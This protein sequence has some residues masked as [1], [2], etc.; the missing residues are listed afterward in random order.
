METI[1]VNYKLN[2][3]GIKIVFSNAFND[4]GIHYWGVILD[5]KPSADELSLSDIYDNNRKAS[6]KNAEAPPINSF[7]DADTCTDMLLN[8]KPLY[9]LEIEEDEDSTILGVHEL[10]KEN[11]E[12]GFASFISRSL[13]Q[14]RTG[15]LI[16]NYQFDYGNPEVGDWVIQQAIFNEMRYG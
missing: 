5:R 10:N 7:P 2:K 6:E 13:E 4:D 16:F 11:F 8:G 3:E 1:N 9:V 12:K 15:G 14:P